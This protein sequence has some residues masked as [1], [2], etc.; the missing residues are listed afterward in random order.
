MLFRVFWGGE[1]PG[2]VDCDGR[3]AGAVLLGSGRVCRRRGRAVN[4]QPEPSTFVP[5]PLPRCD[6]RR[7]PAAARTC[8]RDCSRGSSAA[9]AQ[10]AT[11]YST[12]RGGREERVLLLR[13]NIFFRPH[14][15]ARCLQTTCACQAAAVPQSRASLF[16]VVLRSS[17]SHAFHFF[18]VIYERSNPLPLAF[19]SLHPAC[20]S[21]CIIALGCFVLA[22]PCVFAPMVKQNL[23]ASKCLA[24]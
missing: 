9:L 15:G 23:A 5:S 24:S 10:G 3:G 6:G 8:Q 12:A 13:P 21:T 11:G 20:S 2:P 18:T 17:A 1:I 14:R 22:S 7:G 16:T 4:F 19:L